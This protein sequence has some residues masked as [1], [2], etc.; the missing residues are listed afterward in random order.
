MQTW[1]DDEEREGVASYV[2]SR[3]RME[4]AGP[5]DP[6]DMAHLLGVKIE[7]LRTP[8]LDGQCIAEPP[9]IWLRGKGSERTR[10]WNLAHELSH[11]AAIWCRAPDPHCELSIDD[12][13]ARILVPSRWVR[14][15]SKRG[16]DRE[17][18]AA[19]CEF[20]TLAVAGRR[21]RESLLAE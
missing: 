5:I 15:A 21:V 20:V 10:A 16:M 9:T 6:W 18:I 3:A 17:R 14:S 1:L 2:I 4:H 11:L 7:P 13:A 8:G 12:I 19:E